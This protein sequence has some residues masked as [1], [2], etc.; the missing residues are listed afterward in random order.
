[1]LRLKSNVNKAIFRAA[2]LCK[3]LKNI[4]THTHRKVKLETGLKDRY[5]EMNLHPCPLKKQTKLPP[6]TMPLLH[7]SLPNK[8]GRQFRIV[9]SCN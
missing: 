1:M 7:C 6:P 5:I 3:Y 8:F 9:W 2:S 4:F